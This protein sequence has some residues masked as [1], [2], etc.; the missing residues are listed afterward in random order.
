MSISP[1]IM[2]FLNDDDIVTLSLINNRFNYNIYQEYKNLSWCSL[3]L[4]KLSHNSTP[5]DLVLKYNLSWKNVYNQLY[6]QGNNLNKI[7]KKLLKRVKSV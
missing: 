6:N 5:L 1:R 2:S 4:E 7:L 3:L